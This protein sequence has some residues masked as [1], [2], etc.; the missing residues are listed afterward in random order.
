M[1]KTLR[2]LL[3]LA[4]LLFVPAAAQESI[5][6]LAIHHVT[7]IDAV[8]KA[9]LPDQ[10]VIITGDRITAL[11]PAKRVKIPAEAE[12]VDATGKFLIPG[13]WDMHLHLTNQPDQTVSRELLLPLLVTFGVTGVREMGGDWERLQQ[14]RQ[15]V[16]SGQVLG[17]RLVLAGPFVDGPGFVD[18]PVRT[19]DEARQQVRELKTRGVDFIKVQANL[20]PEVYRAVLA[21]AKQVGLKVAGHVPEAVSAF[22]VARGGQVSI[23]HSSAILPGDAALLLACSGKEEALRA[24]LLALKAD[25]EKPDANRPA[26]RARERALQT[27]MLETFDGRKCASLGALLKQNNVF[28]VPTQIW[29]KRLFPLNLE[30]GLEAAAKPYLPQKTLTRL[31]ARRQAM[32]KAST[33]ESFALRQQI[34]EKTRELVGALRLYGVPLLAGTDGLD[35]DVLPG[36]GVHQELELMVQAGLTPLEALQ[37]ATRNPAQFFGESAARGSIAVGKIAD[38]VLLDANPLQDIANTRKVH[39]VVN[40]GQLLSATQRQALLAKLAAL[41]KQH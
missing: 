15:A 6:P 30:D 10:T 5:K 35:G 17:P 18:K 16:T 7:V 11:G 36:L 28:V 27:Q 26:L 14:L 12:V 37:T 21:E 20:A 8:S 22:E 41:A 32:L 38:L 34:A 31:E 2:V 24:E 29:G 19:P 33:P 9:P 1:T 25:A 3:T 13:L 40:G 39:A 4:V 23:E